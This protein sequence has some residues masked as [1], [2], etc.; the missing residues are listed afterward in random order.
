MDKICIT[1][2]NKKKNHFL[3]AIFLGKA[4]PEYMTDQVCQKTPLS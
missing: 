3:Y 4:L 2:M 1:V